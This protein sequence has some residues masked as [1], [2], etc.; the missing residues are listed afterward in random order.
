MIE[1]LLHIFGIAYIRHW[2]SD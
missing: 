2:I 1:S